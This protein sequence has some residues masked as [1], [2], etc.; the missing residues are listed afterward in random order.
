MVFLRRDLGEIIASQNAMLDARG[1][2]RGAGDDRMHAHYEQHLEQVERF[3]A[4]RS[5]FSTLMVNYTDVLI[6]PREEAAR[7][8][9]FM[10]GRLD[11]SAWLPSPTRRSTEAAAS[12]RGSRGAAAT[13]DKYWSH[14]A[15]Q[16]P[17]LHRARVG[18][19][20]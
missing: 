1:E 11:A 16:V 14:H 5:C 20:L 3:L 12:L 6:R 17:L 2:A 15:Q 8:N 13:A 4:R 10:G 18:P 7:I 9:A 19:R